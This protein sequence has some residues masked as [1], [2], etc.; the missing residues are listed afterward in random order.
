MLPWRDLLK[1]AV[2]LGIGPAAFWQLSLREWIWLTAESGESLT[3]AAL[4]DLMETNPDTEKTGGR[5]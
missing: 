1:A 4:T 5:D 3:R 2:L